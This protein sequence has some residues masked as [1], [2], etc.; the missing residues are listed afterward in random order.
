VARREPGS[1]RRSRLHPA[2]IVPLAFLGAIAIGTAFLLLPQS[3][4]G[5]GAA[6]PL[7]ALF[8]ATSAVCVTGHI[9]VDTPNYW[10]PF[11]QGVILVLIQ[12]GGFGIMTAATLLS[13]LVSSQL[14]LTDR[15]IVQ[16]EVRA[17]GM[18]DIRALVFRIGATVLICEAVVAAV[19]T[20]RLRQAYDLPVGDAVWHGVFHAVSSFNNAG[21][22][23]FSDNLVGFVADWWICAAVIIAIIVGGAGFPVLL[24]LMRRLRRPSTWSTHTRITVFGTV[25]LLSS[26]L[27][28]T[29]IMEWA[30]P[31][32][33]GPLG[34]GTKVLAAA[35]H[36]TSSRTAGFNTVDMTAL[37]P[38]TWAVTDVLM[39]IGGGSAGTAGG[40]KVTTFF[41]LAFVIWSEIRGEPDVVVG[42]RR[43]AGSTVRQAL[44]VVL[45]GF[46]LVATATLALLMIT[47]ESLDRVL[48][49]AVSAF[50]TVGLSTGIT[51]DLPAAAQ[52][53]LVMLMFVGR[54]GTI[55][56][57]A[58]LALNT[59][60][61]L[62]RL[63]EERPIVG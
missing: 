10:S 27:A 11:G 44:A 55:T 32:T 59:R 12:V 54:V 24:E 39:F 50:A 2:R 16:A 21:F 60:H 45:L 42:R 51:G 1:P 8:T 4:Q 9:T 58:A 20:V 63:P 37:H 43:I 52:L 5:P 38:E 22:S 25:F 34:V 3:R 48:F 13:M 57:A 18:D 31:A 26:G 40:I 35:F 33:L 49:E 7:T 56:V 14:R 53:I 61:R 28:A 19:L 62:Y 41:L 47:D 36:S 15:L 6:G 23:T 46:G 29:L 17:G 30:N